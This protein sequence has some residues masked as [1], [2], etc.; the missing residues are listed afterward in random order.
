MEVEFIDFSGMLE[1]QD[2]VGPNYK[3]CLKSGIVIKTR[4]VTVTI[5]MF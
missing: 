1:N 5:N 4:R 2:D 3:S